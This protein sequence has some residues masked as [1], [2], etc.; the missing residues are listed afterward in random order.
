MDVPNNV[1]TI[2]TRMNRYA[3]L[4]IFSLNCDNFAD[5]TENK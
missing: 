1:F 4:G 2:P 3:D 5:R